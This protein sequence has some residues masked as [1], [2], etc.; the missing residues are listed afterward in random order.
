[1]TSFPCLTK[2]LL[3][4]AAITTYLTTKYS[5]G[6]V[7]IEPNFH[8]ATPPLILQMPDTMQYTLVLF[9][10]KNVFHYEVNQ[11]KT[12]IQLSALPLNA[13]GT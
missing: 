10:Q 8:N 7:N 2:S 4:H 11:V 12:L 5:N 3:G 9:S 13:L 6:T 1:M